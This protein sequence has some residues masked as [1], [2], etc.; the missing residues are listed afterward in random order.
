MFHPELAKFLAKERALEL[1][2]FEVYYKRRY[3]EEVQK[4]CSARPISFGA[5]LMM[6]SIP[7]YIREEYSKLQAVRR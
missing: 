5:C 1:P 3:R 4:L 2:P 6:A 7:N